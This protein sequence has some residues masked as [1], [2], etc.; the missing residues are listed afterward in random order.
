M[1]FGRNENNRKNGDKQRGPCFVFSV[2]LFP[3]GKAL[4]F[5]NN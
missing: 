3:L 2:Q 5:Y 4:D 1:I